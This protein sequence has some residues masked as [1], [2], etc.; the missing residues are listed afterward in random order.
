MHQA[1]GLHELVHCFLKRTFHI[2]VLLSAHILE[3]RAEAT[4]IVLVEIA[5]VG[6]EAEVVADGK[7]EEHRAVASLLRRLDARKE[8]GL[9]RPAGVVDEREELEDSQDVAQ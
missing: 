1:L 9:H 6:S 2:R 4:A 8:D 5:R 3:T 7:G